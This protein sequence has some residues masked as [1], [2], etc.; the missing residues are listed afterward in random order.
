M[1]QHFNYSK[2]IF[3]INED[4]ARA[5]LCAY[6]AGERAATTMFK[7]LDP[8]IAVDDYVV[9]PTDTRHKMTVVRVIDVDVEPDVTDD[10]QID[11][12]IGCVDR[13]DYEALKNQEDAAVSAIKAAQ[14]K[15]E[16]DE[17]K[18]TMLAGVQDVGPLSLAG[19]GTPRPDAPAL[20][21]DPD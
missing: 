3:L 9:V 21:E 12:I 16:Q 18:Q 11:W 5:V 10:V 4:N 15:R 13:A 8:R 7:T 2:A 17:L 14:R 19:P 6:E 1:T 20:D